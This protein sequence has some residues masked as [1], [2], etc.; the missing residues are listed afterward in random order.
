ML[1]CG[2]RAESVGELVPSAGNEIIHPVSQE[3]R[4]DVSGFQQSVRKFE[5]IQHTQS[6]ARFAVHLLIFP[7]V[8]RAHVWLR[9]RVLC[10]ETLC[11]IRLQCSK[12]DRM[13][14]FFLVQD[15]LDRLVAESAIAIIKNNLLIHLAAFL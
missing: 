11:K 12:M 2:K 3:F 7:E 4:E 8:E 1:G 9:K 10:E 13:R 6:T 14:L 5:V 15:E